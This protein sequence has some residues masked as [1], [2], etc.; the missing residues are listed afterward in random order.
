MRP[1]MHKLR[2]VK[3]FTLF[4]LSCWL[5][6][7]TPAES[8]SAR[9]PASDAVVAAPPASAAPVPA[10]APAVTPATEP[11]PFPVSPAVAAAFAAADRSVDD[12]AL[13][14]GRKADQLLSFC[15]VTPGMRVAEL[16]AGGG[17][18]AELLA[19]VVGPAGRVY[20]QNAKFFLERF[21]EKPWSERLTKPVLKNVTRVDR[22]FDDP[23]P[24]D[25]KEL[26]VVML[27]LFY[28]DTVW[29]GT[30]R[31]RMNRAV[32]AALRPGGVYCVVDHS[33]REGTGAT[34]TQTLHRIEERVVKEE[35]ERGGFVLD[36]TASFLKNPADAR[37][38]SASP[39]V[40]AE[41]RGTSD[42][43][44]LRFKKPATK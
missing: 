16:A 40:A 35:I 15:G 24:S 18:T 21:A 23:L 10:P 36:A 42:R 14:A 20:G 34:E 25:A 8:P 3:L 26:D 4:P 28:H 5:S 41:R 22:E 32:L 30:D 13:D 6:A 1:R 38:W 19:R 29:H 39:R 2:G 12:R 11:T 33:G 43:F 27:V 31:D 37:D 17:Y 44:V 7:C 9:S